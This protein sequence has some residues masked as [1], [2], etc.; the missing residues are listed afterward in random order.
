MSEEEKVACKPPQVGVS[1]LECAICMETFNKP[2]LLYCMHTFCEECIN[3]IV[4]RENSHGKISCPI[5][6]HETKV[7]ILK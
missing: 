3:K 4:R 6:R 1:E 2:K 5:C 7:C